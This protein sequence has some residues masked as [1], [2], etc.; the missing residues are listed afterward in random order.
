MRRNHRFAF[1]AIGGLGLLAAVA[2]GL[3]AGINVPQT[4]SDRPAAGQGAVA[5]ETFE[6]SEINWS[7][8]DQST[9]VKE[10]TFTIERLNGVTVTSDDATVRIR[11]EDDVESP[12]DTTAW[13]DCAIPSDDFARCTFP[14]EE[15]SM[16]ADEIGGVNVVAFDSN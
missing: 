5:V 2:P 1:L 9:V 15:A 12:A 4:A 3:A 6:V 14:S 7:F 8:F 11:L 10:V 13:L 16:S